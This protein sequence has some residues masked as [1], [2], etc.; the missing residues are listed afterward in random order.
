MNGDFI[1]VAG[2]VTYINYSNR[3][4]WGLTTS[5]TPSRFVN[6]TQAYEFKRYVDEDG[7]EFTALADTTDLLRI[8]EDQLGVFVQYPLSITKRFEA[9]AGLSYRFFAMTK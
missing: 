7:N 4:P 3:L 1:D 5:H 6:Y 8:F 9:G 2:A